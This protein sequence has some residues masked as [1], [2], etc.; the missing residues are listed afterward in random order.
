MFF[1]LIIG[2]IAVGVAI[3]RLLAV[4]RNEESLPQF[5]LILFMAGLFLIWDFFMPVPDWVSALFWLLLVAALVVALL[6]AFSIA[7]MAA[8]AVASIGTLLLLVSGIFTATPRS[9]DT[10]AAQPAPTATIQVKDDNGDTKVL[11][12][13]GNK[14]EKVLAAHETVNDTFATASLKGDKTPVTSWTD[15]WNRVHAQ[16]DQAKTE[17]IAAFNERAKILGITW[18]RVPLLVDAEKRGF[19]SRVIQSVNLTMT[20][21]QIRLLAK[22]VAGDLAKTL[23]IVRI[24]GATVT[25]NGGTGSALVIQDWADNRPGTHVSLTVPADLAKPEANLAHAANFIGVDTTCTNIGRGVIKQPQDYLPKKSKPSPSPTPSATV[26]TTATPTPTAT[27]IVT[28]TPTATVTPT[29]TPTPTATVTPTP[30]PTATVTP[31]PTATVTPT[32]TPTPTATVTQPGKEP[33]KDP[34]VNGNAPTNGAPVTAEPTA[35]PPKVDET[36]APVIYTTPPAPPASEIP[37]TEVPTPG[38][39]QGGSTD[40]PVEGT[41]DEDVCGALCGGGIETTD[42]STGSALGLLFFPFWA[43]AFVGKKRSNQRRSH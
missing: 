21:E 11:E 1:L 26:T 32:A 41:V 6:V 2:I 43:I 17:Y 35:A 40:A 15:L 8:V 37:R 29:A 22:E 7:W 27:V 20:D 36:K 24:E 19:D 25:T 33:T 23:P 5:S 30:T 14:D 16:S 3:W 10:E 9:S 38:P 42:A 31:T 18:E 28:P 12:F 34:A 13:H 4:R 39:N